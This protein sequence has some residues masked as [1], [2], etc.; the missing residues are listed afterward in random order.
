M[1]LKISK[2]KRQTNYFNLLYNSIKRIPY[3]NSIDL[4]NGIVYTPQVDLD[5]YTYFIKEDFV[6]TKE[7]LNCEEYFKI[8][9]ESPILS[10]L[11]IDEKLII[12]VGLLDTAKNPI[13]VNNQIVGYKNIP[14]GAA[15]N[16]IVT[17]NEQLINIFNENDILDIEEIA[18]DLGNKLKRERKSKIEATKL[19]N[20]LNPIQKI[21][22]Q[23]TPKNI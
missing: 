10:M 1:A 2:T 23:P 5:K 13:I 8:K 16:C 11:A 4:S 14:K 17:N 20:K 15:Y 18:W 22:K 19:K 21:Q 7:M 6:C 9:S 3:R 12:T